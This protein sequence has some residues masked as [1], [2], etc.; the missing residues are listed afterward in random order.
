MPVQPDDVRNQGIY[1]VEMV[2]DWGPPLVKITTN[3]GA[4][5]HYYQ[6]KNGVLILG[7]P[8]ITIHGYYRVSLFMPL[9]PGG[10]PIVLDV[11]DTR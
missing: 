9:E 2:N 11:V 5:W 7:R 4:W 3:D 6:N 10:F 8:M 1:E